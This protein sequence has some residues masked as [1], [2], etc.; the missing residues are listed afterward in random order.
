[1]KSYIYGI[2]DDDNNIIY[3]GKSISP[4]ARLFAQSKSKG[5]RRMKI[6]DIYEDLEMVWVRKLLLEGNTLQNRELLKDGEDNWEVGDII[7]S[8][9]LKTSSPLKIKHIPSGIVY[10]SGYAA[11][12]DLEGITFSLTN[13]L[14][15]KPNHPYHSIFQIM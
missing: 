12:K 2:L 10:K 5:F 7:T 15:N 13:I 11:A 3:V 9:I 6:L 4:R 14:K 1:M 8:K